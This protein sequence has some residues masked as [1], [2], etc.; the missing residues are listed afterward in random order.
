MHGQQ[1]IKKVTFSPSFFLP[2]FPFFHSFFLSFLLSIF[3]SFFL[4][5]LLSFFPSV[6]PPFFPSFLLSFLLSIFPSFFLSIFPSFYLSFLLS[7]FLSFL[8]FSFFLSFRFSDWNSSYLF[9]STVHATSFFHLSPFS[10]FTLKL[11]TKC[12]L[13]CSSELIFSFIPATAALLAIVLSSF[14]IVIITNRNNT[15]SYQ[16]D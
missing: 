9:R 8:L 11:V 16:K 12:K 15:K 5:F 2:F 14:Q 4:S 13:R 7:F 3:P 6:F 1:N 10:L